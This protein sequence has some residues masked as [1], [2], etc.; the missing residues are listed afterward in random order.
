MAD[1][2]AAL[3]EAFLVFVDIA[4]VN[5]RTYRVVTCSPQTEKSLLE[6]CCRI[7]RRDLMECV[8]RY[9]FHQSLWEL[10]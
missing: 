10:I 7:Y 1:L 6:G 5:I 8:F 2:V 3:P 9:E 4:A